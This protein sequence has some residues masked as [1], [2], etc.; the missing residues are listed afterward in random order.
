MLCNIKT[1][2][3]I[4]R[5]SQ[6]KSLGYPSL[7]PAKAPLVRMSAA[8]EKAH[9]KISP[10]A[11]QQVGLSSFALLRC[12]P[13][14]ADFAECTDGQQT[15]AAT[16]EDKSALR[17]HLQ[18]VQPGVEFDMKVKPIFIRES[19]KGADKLKGKVAIITGASALVQL[20][21]QHKQRSIMHLN[22]ATD[23]VTDTMQ[24]LLL[25]FILYLTADA[26]S[27]CGIWFSGA[28]GHAGQ[29]AAFVQT[30]R[31]RSWFPPLS[32]GLLCLLLFACSN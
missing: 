21:T 10:S 6:H 24:S 2:T 32:R 22:F 31:T 14:M 27:R 4:Q 9:E 15:C 26:Y 17:M 3:K 13:W 30:W 20:A 8:V 19:Y 28:S 25:P 16:A 5:Y 1:S 12:Y 23:A 29:H 7:R 18:D 11:E